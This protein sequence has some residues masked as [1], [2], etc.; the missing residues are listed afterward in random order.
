[1]LKCVDT[2][3]FGKVTY[4]MMTAYWPTASD[5]EPMIQKAMNGLPK[6][7]PRK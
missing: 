3:L 7:V 6:I 1:M 2:L 4:D 5:K